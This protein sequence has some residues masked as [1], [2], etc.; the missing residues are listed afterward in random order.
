LLHEHCV[1]AT[2]TAATAT[3]TAATA[4]HTTTLL[5]PLDEGL[6]L[7]LL[8]LHGVRIAPTILTPP[9]TTAPTT[10]TTSATATTEPSRGRESIP[11]HRW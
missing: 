2:A 1:S 4:V 9:A 5:L 10:P 3:A 6:D 7:G 8:L 11:H